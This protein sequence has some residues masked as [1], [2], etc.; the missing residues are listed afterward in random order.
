MTV[1]NVRAAF[2]GVRATVRKG[3]SRGRIAYR[4][5][6]DMK[7]LRHGVYGARVIYQIRT[8]HGKFQRGTRVHLF[9]AC[10][11]NPKGGAKT[12]INRFPV[13]IL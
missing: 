3:T 11:G 13:D 10:Y 6:I 7:N 9:R 8:S 2:E 5:R 1:R 12:G 4:V